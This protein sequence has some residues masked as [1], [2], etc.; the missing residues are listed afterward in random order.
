V[1]YGEEGPTDLV[2]FAFCKKHSVLEE[3][4]KRLNAYFAA[5]AG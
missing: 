3:S 2:R 1:F 5:V 4:G